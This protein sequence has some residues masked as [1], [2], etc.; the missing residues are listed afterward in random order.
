ME[1]INPIIHMDED[2]LWYWYEV[3]DLGQATMF[4]AKTFFHR[5]ECQQ[6]HVVT[7]QRIKHRT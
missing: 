5:D 7:V 3:D 6:D 1:D 4:S 2:L